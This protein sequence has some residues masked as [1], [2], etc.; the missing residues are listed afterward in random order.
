MI[1][2]SHKDKRCSTI[3]K[4][5]F[6]KKIELLLKDKKIMQILSHQQKKQE[7]NSCFFSRQLPTF[8]PSCP[9]SIIGVRGLSF[10]VRNGNERF[11]SAMTTGISMIRWKRYS[12]SLRSSPRL[13]STPRLRMLPSFHREP[14]NR[15]IFPESYLFRVGYLILGWA[16]HLDAFSAYP[17]RTQLPSYAPGGTTGKPEVRPSRSS[18]TRDSSPQVSYAHDR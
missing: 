16:S 18:R 7:I 6:L 12:S 8:P 5:F 13:I 2:L 10:R 9:G 3:R 4:E 14:I 15:V 17:L 11:P 1:L